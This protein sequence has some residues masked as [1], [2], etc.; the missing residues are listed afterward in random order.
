M[1]KICKTVLA[2]AVLLLAPLSQAAVIEW[3]YQVTLEWEDATF[4]NG[5]ANANAIVNDSLISWG[6]L[7]GDHTDNSRTAENS[8]SGLEITDSPAVGTIFTNDGTPEATNSIT[9]YNN[10]IAAEFDTLISGSLL[11]TLNLTPIDPPGPAIP[12][13]STLFVVDFFETPN[14]APCDFPSATVCDD[15][16]VLQFGALDS[17]FVYDGVTYFLNI[18]ELSGNLTLLPAATCAAVGVDTGCVG[19]TT[20]EDA[21]TPVQFGFTVTAVPEP[22]MLGIFGLGLLVLN[23]FGRRR[24]ARKC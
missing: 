7:G 18:V 16:F 8:R 12:E 23:A 15:I 14:S 22:A 9:H 5:G 4:N 3:S 13:F 6:A 24:S 20:P 17:E 1:N 19:L 11:T 21:F 10:A 2:G